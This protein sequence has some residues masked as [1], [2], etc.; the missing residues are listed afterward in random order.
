MDEEWREFFLLWS[1]TEGF[2]AKL[3]ATHKRLEEAK[4]HCKRPTIL[5]SGGKDS[6]VGVHLALHHFP[7]ILIFHYDYTFNI[8]RP[9]AVEILENLKKLGA[10]NVVVAREE[11]PV[12]D[13]RGFFSAVNRFIQEREVDCVF[14][15]LRAEESRKRKALTQ[16]D[17]RFQGVRNI[18]ILK[19]WTWKDVWAY[20]VSR[21]LP[22][23]SV[24]DK[25][26]ELEGWDKVRF[27]AFFSPDLDF[28]GKSNVDGVLM[29]RYRNL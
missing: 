12:P 18:H 8:P 10:K 7:D 23:L 4:K 28:L 3:R 20:I 17:G 1:E 21:G 2:K 5:Y 15:C 9:V 25:Y 6:T 16:K 14:S 26:A 11:K 13:D 27:T 24:Y 29:W 19:D 22:Y